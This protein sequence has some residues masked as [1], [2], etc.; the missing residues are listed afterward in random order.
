MKN[1]PFSTMLI[2]LLAILS[3]GGLYTA[4]AQES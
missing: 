4:Y 3:F 1:R 2:L